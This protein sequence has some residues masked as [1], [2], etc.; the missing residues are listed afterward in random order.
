MVTSPATDTTILR[1][2]PQLGGVL[3]ELSREALKTFVFAIVG[4]N[5]Q[6]AAILALLKQV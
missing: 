1:R 4:L 3:P 6:R 5:G 2:L